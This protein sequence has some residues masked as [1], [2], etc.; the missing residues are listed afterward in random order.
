M[1]PAVSSG[2]ETRS[3]DLLQQLPALQ[4]DLHDWMNLQQPTHHARITR[5]QP[6]PAAQASL[7]Y[8]AEGWA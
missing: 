4:R 6:H 3:V 1:L 8:S 5:T 2:Q 7:A